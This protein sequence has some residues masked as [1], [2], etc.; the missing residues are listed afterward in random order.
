M[1]VDLA[2]L[3]LPN[4]ILVAS[5]CGGTG[6]ELAAYGALGDLGGVVTR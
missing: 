3:A 6:R 2:G 5:G 4:P 1:S